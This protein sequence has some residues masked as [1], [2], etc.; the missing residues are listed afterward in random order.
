VPHVLCGGFT[1]SET[2]HV[3]IDLHFLGIE[4]VLALRGD[5]IKNQHIFQPEKDGHANANE[6]VEQIVNLKKGIYLEEEL[7]NNTPLDGCR[8]RLHCYPN[9]F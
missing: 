4:N 7:K 8:S 2:E 5:G 6:L 9:V 1:K 3:L